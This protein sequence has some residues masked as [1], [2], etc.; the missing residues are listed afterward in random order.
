MLLEIPK[1]KYL[2][3]FI[4]SEHKIVRLFQKGEKYYI[5]MTGN[6]YLVKFFTGKTLKKAEKRCI[7]VIKKIKAGWSALEPF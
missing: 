5:E 2:K 7:D 1:L 3:T 6:G 4:V